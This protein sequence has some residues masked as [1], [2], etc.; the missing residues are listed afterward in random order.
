LTGFSERSA[1]L[2]LY[3]VTAITGVSA[4]FVSRTDTLTTPTVIIPLLVAI[5]LLGIYLAQLRVYPEK[6]FALL[7]ERSYTPIL[8][9]ITY[10]KQLLLV[11]FDLCLISFS[12]YLA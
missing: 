6:E 9:D 12:Y 2:F 8:F 5:L 11:F 4:V 1:V 10:K 7:R 3:L